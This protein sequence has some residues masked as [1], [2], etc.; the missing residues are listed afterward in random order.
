MIKPVKLIPAI[1][2]FIS[3]TNTIANPVIK[4]AN[5]HVNLIDQLTGRLIKTQSCL[6]TI[7][8]RLEPI[9]KKKQY[10]GI[11]DRYICGT[12]YDEKKLINLIANTKS[13]GI[14]DAVSLNSHAQ[15]L[16]DIYSEINKQCRD[17]EIYIRLKD[18]KKDNGKHADELYKNLV[19][20][21]DKYF[22]QKTAYYQHLCQISDVYIKQNSSITKVY[23]KMRSFLFEE[24]MHLNTLRHN[25]CESNFTNSLPV[26]SM[27]NRTK[28][29]DLELL[30]I[31]KL[32]K[33]NSLKFV[34]SSKNQL[35]KE[36]RRAVDRYSGENRKTDSHMN[37]HIR[38]QI[39]NLNDFVTYEFNNF[40]IRTKGELLKYPKTIAVLKIDCETKDYQ[41]ERKEYIETEI[42]ELSIIKSPKLISKNTTRALNNYIE[43][44]NEELRFHYDFA[45]RLYSL[46]KKVNSFPGDRP[47][48]FRL[49][50][51]ISDAYAVP[52]AKY[53]QTI[54][55]SKYIHA[56][57]RTTLNIILKDLMNIIKEKYQLMNE[58]RLYVTK[59]EYNKDSCR[60]AHIYLKRFEFLL[61]KL[62]EKKQILYEYCRKV[63]GRYNLP[64]EKSWYKSANE[65][66]KLTDETLL[67][68]NRLKKEF[69]KK[70][71]QNTTSGNINQIA[72]QILIDEYDNL[73]GIR[74]LGSN[75]GAC[76]YNPYEDI[77]KSAINMIESIEKFPISRNFERY[78]YSK[79]RSFIYAYNDLIYDYNHFVRIGEGEYDGFDT[80]APK[81]VF[82]LKNIRQMMHFRYITPEKKEK[83]EEEKDVFE[84]DEVEKKDS[85]SMEGFA[86]NNLVLLL[87]VSGSMR[88]EDKLPLLK[89]S[90]IE[91]LPH[92]RLED[93]L[94][95]VSFSGKGKVVLKPTSCTKKDKINDAL[96][97]LES[98]GLTNFSKGIKLAYK[99]AQSNFKEDANNRIIVA[100]DGAFSVDDNIYELT[101]NEADKK[102]YLS[103][104]S[105]G[106]KE[107]K[108]KSLNKLAKVGKGNYENIETENATKKL[109][110]ELQAIKVKN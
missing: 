76:P 79:Y 62:D 15:K 21:F 52:Y 16:Y 13:A 22:I 57:Y 69:D 94:S 91:L 89:A 11:Y 75:N 10:A 2:L 68:I 7:Y 19:K 104:F 110:R 55:E 103:V 83:K 14:K 9:R 72:R 23:N 47:E 28:K 43:F 92:L 59:K 51:M 102:I 25:F 45:E 61:N 101:D 36:R 54:N 87:D 90:L 53:E 98:K 29:A 64:M 39:I 49:S 5:Q 44:I 66:L 73:K 8:F 96:E 48:Y 32:D 81:N 17:L 34:N 33:T 97:K 40:I 74:K 56:D 85:I 108:V 50:F 63:H 88:A 100:T 38:Y 95:I 93:E 60:Q 84:K 99:T 20:L 65:M 70:E 3:I 106:N 26:D 12:Q 67:I 31:E 6:H 24:E 71:P 35:Q 37:N 46:N 77:A 107:K 86:R 80:P 41:I 42:P 27:L 58:M 105:F 4:I 109:L 78:R 18:Y 82:L 1:V 30:E